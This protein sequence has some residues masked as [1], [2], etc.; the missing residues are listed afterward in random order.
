MT[1][2]AVFLG[3]VVGTGARM[4]ADWLI[5]GTGIATLVVNG[6]GSF[7]LGVL[8]S[9]L[10]RRA[11]HWL[12]AGLGVGVLGSFTTYSTVALAGIRFADAGDPATAVL[13]LAANLLLGLAAAWLGLRIGGRPTPIDWR[14]E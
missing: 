13:Y 10:W 8:V 7:A 1:L 14:D 12:R 3:G 6:V 2:L 9:S 4:A 5:P 11:P